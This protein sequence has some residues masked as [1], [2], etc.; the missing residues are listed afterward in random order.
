MEHV[1]ENLD[2]TDPNVVREYLRAS[3][4]KTDFLRR[5]VTMRRANGGGVPS[6]L[7]WQEVFGLNPF[8]ES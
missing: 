5:V 7:T 3:K 2:L 6:G 1:P 8:R 4:S